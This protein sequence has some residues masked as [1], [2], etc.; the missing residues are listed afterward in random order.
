MFIRVPVNKLHPE[1]PKMQQLSKEVSHYQS[2]CVQSWVGRMALLHEL[3]QE[4]RFFPSCYSTSCIPVG[5]KGQERVWD[6]GC[7]GFRVENI[8][9]RCR[10]H[11]HPFPNGAN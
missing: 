7:W 8:I 5:G 3:T 6:L 2:H 1:K 4:P 11:F 10:H 9:Q